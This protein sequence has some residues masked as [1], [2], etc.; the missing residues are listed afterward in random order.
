MT[1][2][3]EWSLVK[4]LDAFRFCK[5]LRCRS[6]GCDL[7][8]P[9]RRRGL[10]AK[11]ASGEPT[12]FLTLTVNP[13]RGGSPEERLAGLA[14]AWR[15]LVKR[16]RRANPTDPIEYLAIVELTKRGEPH[17]HILLRSPYIPHALISAAMDELID[18]PIVDIRR[19]REPK[20]VIRY[21]AKYLTKANVR[22]GTAKRYWSSRSYE[23]DKEEPFE[24]ETWMGPGWTIDKRPILTILNEWR[25]QQYTCSRQAVDVWSA[26]YE[27]NWRPLRP[28]EQPP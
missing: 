26:E 19:I 7:C 8:S 20:E 27:P 17:L 14:H 28:L 13:R 5:P 11:A 10:M 23:L 4:H 2:C 22:L 21:V 25:Y 18:A 1:L 3:R 9:D 24:P 6:W 16:L 12:R 15:I